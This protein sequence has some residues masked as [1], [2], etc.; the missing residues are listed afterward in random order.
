MNTTETMNIG[1]KERKMR[2]ALGIVFLF[3]SLGV[4][5]IFVL[6]R[7]NPLWALILLPFYYQGVRFIL[8]YRTGTCP[9]KAE[10]GQYK[11]DAK[12]SILGEKFQDSNLARAIQI[13]SRKALVQA[14]LAGVVLTLLN[15]LLIYVNR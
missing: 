2:R 8:D 11:L 14:G 10:L 7:I 12:F 13:K 6:N 1:T 5:I 3:I 9:L 4:G 15:M